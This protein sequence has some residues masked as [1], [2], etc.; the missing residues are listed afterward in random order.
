MKN[1]FAILAMIFFGILIAGAVFIY[2]LSEAL[3]SLY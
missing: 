1:M 2:L 3:Q